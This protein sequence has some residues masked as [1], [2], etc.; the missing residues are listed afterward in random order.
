MLESVCKLF[1]TKFC[2]NA[3]KVFSGPEDGLGMRI[4]MTRENPGSVYAK[5]RFKKLTGFSLVMTIL[6]PRPSSGPEKTLPAFT[7]N[8]VSKSLQTLS[9]K[10]NCKL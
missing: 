6:L 3:G 7:Q 8:F 10:I 5:F 1:E 4:V 9:S 2:V